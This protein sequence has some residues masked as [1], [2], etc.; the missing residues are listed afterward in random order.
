MPT[1]SRPNAGSAPA[2]RFASFLE[3]LLVA[4]WRVGNPRRSLGESVVLTAAVVLIGLVPFRFDLGQRLLHHPSDNGHAL[5]ALRMGFNLAHCGAYSRLST[6][7]DTAIQEAFRTPTSPDRPITDAVAAAAGSVDRYC[8]TVTQP[9]QNNENGLLLVAAA[10]FAA[11]PDASMRTLGTVWTWATVPLLAIFSLALL[12]AGFSAIFAVLEFWVALA[13]TVEIASSALYSN[14]MLVPAYGL[15]LVGGLSMI[16]QFGLHRRARTFLPLMAV[17][18]AS[19]GFFSVLRTNYGLIFLA[20]ALVFVAFVSG[21]LARRRRNA[22]GVAIVAVVCTIAGHRITVGAVNDPILAMGLTYNTVSHSFAH[23]L[24]LAVGQPQSDLAR[25]EGIDWDD[26]K[27]LA[28]AQSV[29]PKATYLGPLYEKALL[30]YYAKLWIY[31][32]GE[33]L[34]IYWTKWKLSVQGSFR[35]LRDSGGRF[36]RALAAPNVAARS[37]V[38]WFFFCLAAMAAVSRWRDRLQPGAAVVGVL[39]LFVGWMLGVEQVLLFPYTTLAYHAMLVFSVC[40]VGLVVYQAGMNL[41]AG[42]AALAW[43]SH[44]ASGGARLASSA[45]DRDTADTAAGASRTE[46]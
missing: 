6:T 41:L 10:A 28:F 8:E 1:T 27:A 7:H 13:M 4:P 24:V 42:W 40:F 34:G 26:S 32:P 19:V 43:A 35:A 31:H 2:L 25:R 46:P 23:P 12:A 16:A 39:L 37:G 17:V 33:M 5:I 30:T 3:R 45:A 9:F 20:L 15:A 29:D 36:A 11:F 44:A 21:D 14:Y 22:V 18:G 38:V